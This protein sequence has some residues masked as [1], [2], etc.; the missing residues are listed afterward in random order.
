LS[1]VI[2]YYEKLKDDVLK[3]FLTLLEC[4]VHIIQNCGRAFLIPDGFFLDDEEK[5]K[6]LAIVRKIN[7]VIG[8]PPISLRINVKEEKKQMMIESLLNN[9]IFVTDKDII[10]HPENSLRFD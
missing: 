8:I 10:D 9:H 3:V 4:H 5:E 7:L 1:S 2:E 6:W